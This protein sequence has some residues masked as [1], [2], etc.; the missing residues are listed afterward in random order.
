MWHWLTI[1]CFKH[2]CWF[3]HYKLYI[4]LLFYFY[5][6]IVLQTSRSILQIPH[7]SKNV[8][9]KSINAIHLFDALGVT[10]PMVLDL[11]SSTESFPE[12]FYHALWA[13]GWV[14]GYLYLIL[15]HVFF[16]VGACLLVKR[17]VLIMFSIWFQF[18]SRCTLKIF[19]LH[20]L[21][22]LHALHL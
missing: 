2:F 3:I 19:S 17:S 5:W 21:A 20:S 12:V 4:F 13:E 11:F 18:F 8:C 14:S 7:S 16:Y 9:S 15:F 22:I 6:S 10:H 1:F